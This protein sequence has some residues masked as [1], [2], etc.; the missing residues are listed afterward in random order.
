[1]GENITVFISEEKIK[2]RI[3][4]I[5][6]QL[7]ELY[8]NETVTLIC[9]LKGAVIF[10]A[11]LM[12]RLNMDV[13][14]EF[15]AVSSYE[16]TDSTGKINMKYPLSEKMTGKNI[17]LVEDILDTGRTLSYL[18]NYLLEQEPKD[19]K[20]ITLLDKPDRRISDIQADIVGFT[21]PDKFV[22]GYG[23]DYDQKFR[24]LPYIGIYNQ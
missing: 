16:G 21:I 5:A 9:T 22:V 10:A 20:L 15:V 3:N 23:L 11:D 12:R 6:V 14:L 19:I 1:M 8:K 13:R 4:E 24:Y 18:K 7:N 17:L 2:N